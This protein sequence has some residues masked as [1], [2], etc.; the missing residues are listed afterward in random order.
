ML[1]APSSPG[2]DQTSCGCVSALSMPGD[3]SFTHSLV[4]L[5]VFNFF[6]FEIDIIWV[7]I[8]PTL[9]EGD[10][11]MIGTSNFRHKHLLVSLK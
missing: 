6:T 4:L 7:L 11:E 3:L 9:W 1:S 5:M 2:S 10:F 8:I